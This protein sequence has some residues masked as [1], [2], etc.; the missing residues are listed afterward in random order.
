MN[1]ATK[2]I[3]AIELTV[4]PEVLLLKTCPPDLTVCV[5]RVGRSWEIFTKSPEHRLNEK[6][7]RDVTHIANRIRAQFDLDEA[8][9]AE[10]TTPTVDS[11]GIATRAGAKQSE[12]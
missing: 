1:K 3:A 6:F 12:A 11:R 5:K 2:S 8:I 7:L 9:E 4:R 10:V